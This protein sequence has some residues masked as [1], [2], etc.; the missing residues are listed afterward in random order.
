V[1]IATNQAGIARGY[2]TQE[3]F[4]SFMQWMIGS[5]GERGAHIDAVYHCP[6]HPEGQGLF[7]VSDHPDRKPNPGMLM[8]AARD[9]DIDLT[10]SALIGD[11]PSDLEAAQRAGIP[12]RGWFGQVETRHQ[13]ATALV[14]HRQSRAWLAAL[15]AEAQ[16]GP[17]AA[18][19]PSRSPSGPQ[20][21]GDAG[22]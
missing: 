5:L 11:Q 6:Y 2:Y 7:A 10:Q 14:D 8:R 18:V 17:S 21:P 3:Q 9:L 1:V 12:H 16:Y 19:P 13:L 22:S 4:E 20:L 15:I